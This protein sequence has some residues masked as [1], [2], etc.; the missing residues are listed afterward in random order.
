MAREKSLNELHIIE[1]VN[2]VEYYNTQIVPLAKKFKPISLDH[3]TGLCPFHGDT[4]PSFHYWKGKGVFHCFGCGF[5]GDVVKTHI[6]LRRAYYNEYL[7]PEQAVKALSLIFNIELDE[8]TGFVIKSP[9]ELARD[10]LLNPRQYQ[11]PRDTLT[12]AEF[13]KSNNK[14]SR[15]KL[16]IHTRVANFAQLD[17]IA[18]LQMRSKE[19][20]TKN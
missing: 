15:A 7:N 12:L 1:E 8:E 4:D 6:Q 14:L 2:L 13:K 18:S 20:E 16:P 10:L 3:N 11:V 17:L 5:G 9:I 19:G